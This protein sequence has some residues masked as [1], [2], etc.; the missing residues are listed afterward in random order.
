MLPV[1]TQRARACPSRA[2]LWSCRY[3]PC[4]RRH[5][6][7]RSQNAA[8]PPDH[9]S[10][11]EGAIQEVSESSVS[12]SLPGM[13][14][15]LAKPVVKDRLAILDF[16]EEKRLREYERA[17][18]DQTK[19]KG[20]GARSWAADSIILQTLQLA[21]VL[22]LLIVWPASAQPGGLQLGRIWVLYFVY[23]A[24]FWL[25][26][27]KRIAN[28]GT[29]ANR[30]QDAQT[31]SVFSRLSLAMFITSLVL[32]HWYAVYKYVAL[33]TPTPWTACERFGLVLMALALPLHAWACDVLGKAYDRVVSPAQLITSGPYKYVQH[34]IYTS[35]MLLFTGYALALQNPLAALAL[36]ILCLLHYGNRTKLESKV[37]SDAF[38]AAY[39]NYKASTKSFLPFLL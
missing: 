21:V 33:W 30:D 4:S 7:V 14:P 3:F 12:N 15:P 23:M 20:Q 34:P 19:G 32:L 16:Y 27:V 31:K 38:G 35:Y 24:F 13:F 37:L 39:Q 22:G 2:F 6:L 36:L 29:L 10:E 28:H 17:M 18:Q 1:C 5:T 8:K 9:G 11:F 25:G 26:A